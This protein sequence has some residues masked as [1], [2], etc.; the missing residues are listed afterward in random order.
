M[1]IFFSVVETIIGNLDTRLESPRELTLFLAIRSHL[2]DKI[3]TSENNETR[4]LPLVNF[5][6]LKEPS[7]LHPYE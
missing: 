5:C 7:K 1:N 2:I 3:Q 4:T 6:N